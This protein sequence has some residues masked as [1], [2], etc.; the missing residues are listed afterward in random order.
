M[1]WVE[2]EF[3]EEFRYYVM[4]FPEKQLPE[5]KRLINEATHVKT[6]VFKSHEEA[7]QYLEAGRHGD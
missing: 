7:E 1:P 4:D 6:M 5:V 2:E 3:D